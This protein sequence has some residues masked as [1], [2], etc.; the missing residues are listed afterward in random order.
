MRGDTTAIHL[1]GVVPPYPLPQKGVLWENDVVWR[2]PQRINVYG[3]SGSGKTTLFRLIVGLA[4]PLSGMV[5]YERDGREA[6]THI[7]LLR[8]ELSVVFQDLR[9]FEEATGREAVQLVAELHDRTADIDGY[10]EMLGVS[11]RI[12]SPVTGLS[13]GERQRVAL[14]RALVRPFRF[15]LLD[16]PFSHLDEE[17]R[18]A[19]WRLIDKRLKEEDA[20]LVL[21]SHHPAGRE[22]MEEYAIG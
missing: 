10:A 14:I 9:V 7:G 16:E 3:K 5:R 12:D 8:E 22:A 15:L 21:L 20:A 2:T 13:Y 17:R 1:H 18:E 19:A 4:K 11:H 6:P